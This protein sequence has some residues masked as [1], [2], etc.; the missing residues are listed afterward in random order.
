MKLSSLLLDG[1]CLALGVGVIQLP[2]AEATVHS[3]AQGEQTLIPGILD[4][5]C[6]NPRETYVCFF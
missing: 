2:E 5:G 1:T 6:P 4:E 3:I